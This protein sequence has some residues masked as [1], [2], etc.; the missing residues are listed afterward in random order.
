MD[1]DRKT[2]RLLGGEEEEDNFPINSSPSPIECRDELVRYPGGENVD[3]VVS[4]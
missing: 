3:R 1:C 4:N 2:V